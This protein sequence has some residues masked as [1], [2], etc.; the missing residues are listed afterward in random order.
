MLIELGTVT[1]SRVGSPARR[2]TAV[3]LDDPAMLWLGLFLVAFPLAGV[4]TEQKTEAAYG[5]P[6]VLLFMGG[7]MVSKAVER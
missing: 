5:D 2:G 6:V 4:L 3:S 7:F 1:S